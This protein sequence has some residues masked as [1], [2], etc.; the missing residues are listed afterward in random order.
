MNHIAIEIAVN[1]LRK[2]ELQW[3][4]WDSKRAEHPFLADTWRQEMAAMECLRLGP[5]IC[6]LRR[7]IKAYDSTLVFMEGDQ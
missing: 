6:D 3:D 1:R 7:E 5:A 2:L 4:F